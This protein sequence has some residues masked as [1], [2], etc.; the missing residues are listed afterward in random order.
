MRAYNTD[1]WYR[2]RQAAEE[3]TAAAAQ[4][5]DSSSSYTVQM[6]EGTEAGDVLPA[7][8]AALSQDALTHLHADSSLPL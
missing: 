6:D 3:D 7:T 4:W 2:G 8:A 1:G 5:D